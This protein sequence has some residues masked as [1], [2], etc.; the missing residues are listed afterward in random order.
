M[1]KNF[2][3][4]FSCGKDSTLALY[5]LIQSGYIPKCLLITTGNDKDSWFHGVNKKLI[6]KIANSLN[7]DVYFLKCNMNSYTEDFIDGLKK[8]KD[9]YNVS[10]CGFGDIDIDIHKKWDEEVS[11]KS[12]LKCLLPLWNKNRE[13]VVYE[14][15][16]LDFKCIIKKIDS[17]KIPDNY[18]GKILTFDIIDEFKD[19][20]IDVC[21]EKGEYHTIVFDGP[22]FAKKVALELGQVTRN[23]KSSSIQVF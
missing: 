21:G 14:F 5:N 19:L 8:I 23:I 6:I 22:L 17:S 2:V 7:I 9:L 13:E 4:A 16:N 10:Y 18:L 20:G 3:M 1:N 11:L 12:G 15:L